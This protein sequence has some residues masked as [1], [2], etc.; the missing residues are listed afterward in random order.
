MG[1]DLV[2]PHDDNVDTVSNLHVLHPLGNVVG[3]FGECSRYYCVS[4]R[5]I[6]PSELRADTNQFKPILQKWS[7]SLLAYWARVGVL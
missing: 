5:V 3:L 2:T 7:P 4:A 1:Q 6:R